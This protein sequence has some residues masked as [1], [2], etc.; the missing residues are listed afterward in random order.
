MTDL[1]GAEPVE[2]LA[3]VEQD[4]QGA[5]REAQGAEA[6]PVEL[7]TRIPPGVR[8]E[9]GHAEEGE[10]ADRQV[11]VEDV[12]PACSSRSA[13]RRAPARGSGRP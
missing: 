1:A 8:Q 7:R 13:S 6:E 9:D 10:D 4:L 3:A 11:D 12:A 5:D 2:L